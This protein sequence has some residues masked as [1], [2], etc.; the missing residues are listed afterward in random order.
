VVWYPPAF[1]TPLRFLFPFNQLLHIMAFSI[2]LEYILNGIALSTN[3]NCSI[4]LPY[5]SRGVNLPVRHE[6]YVI[7]NHMNQ[8]KFS[9]TNLL[10]SYYTG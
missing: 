5:C 3:K 6:G 1:L 7:Y 2:K 10:C 8:I 4:K 9:S